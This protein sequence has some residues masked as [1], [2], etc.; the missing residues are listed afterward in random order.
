MLLTCGHMHRRV[1]VSS[2]HLCKLRFVTCVHEFDFEKKCPGETGAD[3]GNEPTAISCG[4]AHTCALLKGGGVLC[5]GSN[6]Y[7]QL[8]TGN[9]AQAVSPSV[10]VSG[11]PLGM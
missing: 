1:F 11:L 7:G 8:G 6:S 10:Q 2:C 4:A 3:A 9:T 5:W